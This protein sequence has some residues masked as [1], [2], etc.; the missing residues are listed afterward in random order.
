MTQMYN[1]ALQNTKY[2]FRTRFK[3]WF[4]LFDC[5]IGNVISL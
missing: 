1:K 5:L 3:N 2:I 4:W